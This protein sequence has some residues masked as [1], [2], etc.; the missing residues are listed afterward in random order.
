MKETRVERG[1]KE[2]L[3]PFSKSSVP[4]IHI[5]MELVY[6][7]ATSYSLIKI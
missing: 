5:V 6:N 4:D 2:S 3:T 7:N 1:E